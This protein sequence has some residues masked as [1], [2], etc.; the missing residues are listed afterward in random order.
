MGSFL[1]PGR[2][3]AAVRVEVE[4]GETSGYVT[5]CASRGHFDPPLAHHRQA[6]GPRG[7][8]CAS[9]RESVAS[10]QVAGRP[11]HL[12]PPRP[13]F[14]LGNLPLIVSPTINNL[15]VTKMLAYGGTGL[16]LLST[17][18]LRRLQIPARGLLPT[19]AF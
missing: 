1:V 18:L 12:G 6:V 5:Y 13:L 8:H 7:V 9:R 10:P 19:G 16:N 2:M 11:G 3:P 17:Q 15:R 14:G 4:S